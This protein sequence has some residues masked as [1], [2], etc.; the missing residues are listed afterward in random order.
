MVLAFN[1]T[2][3]TPII[4]GTIDNPFVCEC[5]FESADAFILTIMGILVYS[6]LFIRIYNK[7]QIRNN[8][9]TIDYGENAFNFSIVIFFCF[10]KT[11]TPE[12]W[13]NFFV[14][15]L[16]IIARKFI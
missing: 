14:I 7:I 2:N 12:S 4:N 1:L 13:I 15:L 6:Y 5:F 16:L 9:E 8:K 11:I 10:F 3:I